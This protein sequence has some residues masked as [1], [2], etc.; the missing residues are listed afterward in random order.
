[1]PDVTI[2][3]GRLSTLNVF[4]IS[5]SNLQKLCVK[6]RRIEMKSN[7]QWNKLGHYVV[8]SVFLYSNLV[9]GDI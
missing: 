3:Y 7:L 9:R 8:M 2:G 1:M 4:V 6:A 5:S